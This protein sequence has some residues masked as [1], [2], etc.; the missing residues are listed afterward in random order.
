MTTSRMAQRALSGT[1]NHSRPWSSQTTA[2]P[3]TSNSAT[4]RYL[5]GRPPF[6]LGHC[7]GTH[8]QATPGSTTDVDGRA[9][10]HRASDA[11][12][13]CAAGSV[14]GVAVHG[15]GYSIRVG[16][17]YARRHLPRRSDRDSALSAHYQS[18]QSRGPDSASVRASNRSRYLNEYLTQYCGSGGAHRLT[19]RPVR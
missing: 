2:P 1:Q 6:A 9:D 15:A 16:G 18:G 7:T 8:A 14:S 5:N 11:L 4:R 12:I 19:T 17:G 13:D 3:E 10:T